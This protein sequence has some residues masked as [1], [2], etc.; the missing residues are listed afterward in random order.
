MLSLNKFFKIKSSTRKKGFEE[1]KVKIESTCANQAKNFGFSCNSI[2]KKLF[3]LING[4]N[5][6]KKIDTRLF[7]HSLFWI[8]IHEMK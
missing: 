5:L 2:V 4:L 7:L 6:R 8:V 3:I 1:A